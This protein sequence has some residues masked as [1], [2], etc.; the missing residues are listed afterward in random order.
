MR[1]L[2]GTDDGLHAY[3]A[4]GHRLHH[5]GRAITALGPPRSSP[6]AL[7]DAGEVWRFAD[8]EWTREA[9][10]DGARG[11]CIAETAGGVL[12][13]TAE[14]HLCRMIDGRVE[15]VDAFERIRG[16]DSWYTPWGG[17][18]DSRSISEDDE[19]V[20]VNVHVGGIPRSFD[21]GASWEPTIEVD[22]DVHR[23]CATPARVFAAC[24]RGLAVS[25]D[26]GTSWEIRTEGLHATYCRGVAICPDAV[27]VSASTG[28]RG[29][30][31]AVYRGSP[32]G[33]G[34][35]RCESGLP[36]CFDVN[37]DSACLD[38]LPSEASAAFGT[39]DGRV[40]ASTDAGATWDE[41]ASDLPPVRCLTLV[42]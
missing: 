4:S 42:P 17:P 20:Y 23:V 14:A 5:A 19:A 24:A 31:S 35:E 28:P 33:G 9:T 22:A 18:P 12:V 21:A 36:E 40:F 25:G 16:R 13:G 37:I 29:G 10:L 15:D 39:A 32:S 34:F 6:W 11:A 26:H 3:D 30:R 2:A 38:A 8:G 7:I 1:I 27:L 41:V